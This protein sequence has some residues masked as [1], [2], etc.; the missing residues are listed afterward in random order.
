[1]I[2]GILVL[3]LGACSDEDGSLMTPDYGYE[4]DT[5]AGNSEIYEFTPRSHPGKTCVMYM[6][7]PGLLGFATG[8]D[9]MGLQC[10]DKPLGIDLKVGE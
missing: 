3:A 9:A 10:F 8:G 7:D 6:L 4:I 1:M 5:W 2:M